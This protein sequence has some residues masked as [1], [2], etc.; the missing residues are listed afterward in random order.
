MKLALLIAYIPPYRIPLFKELS[1]KVGDVKF[2]LSIPMEPNRKWVAD[3][4]DL[5]VEIQK[6]L[7]IPYIWRHPKGFS[8]VLYMHFPYNTIRELWNYS[9]DVIISV[10]MGFRTLQVLIYKFLKPKAKLIIWASISEHT[11]LGRGWVRRFLR[12]FFLL[13]ADAVLVNGES[14]ARYI[15]QFGYSK[16]RIVKVPYTTDFSI[17]QYAPMIE[18][19]NC[20]R[21]ILYVGRLEQRKGLLALIQ[22]VK[23]LCNENDDISVEFVLAGSG[24][25]EFEIKE[26][27]LPENFTIQ[28]MGDVVFSKLPAIYRDAQIFVFPTLADEWGMVVSEAMAIGRPVLGSLYSQAV[29]ELVTD[30]VNGWVFKPDDLQWMKEKVKDALFSSSDKLRTLG[31]SARESVQRHSPEFAS[32]QMVLAINKVCGNE[33]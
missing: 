26:I 30:G 20:Q 8:E 28:L 25:L 15:Q 23:E 33:P 3:Y 29:E 4:S 17:F 11:E 6:S 21:K 22:I 13:F 31:E 18:G 9:P 12:K 16:D 32:D 14:G 10:E 2:L 5:N 19:C 27:H 24:P 7:M 1:S